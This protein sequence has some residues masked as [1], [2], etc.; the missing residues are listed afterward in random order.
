MGHLY[1][2][3]SLARKEIR[4]DFLSLIAV[5]EQARRCDPAATIRMREEICPAAVMMHMMKG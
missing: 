2:S 1:V 3:I 4:G 5:S